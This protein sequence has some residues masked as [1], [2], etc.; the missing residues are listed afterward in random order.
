MFKRLTLNFVL[1]LLFAFAQIGAVRHE[2]SH[3]S[4]YK[5][6]QQ[7]N[8]T[9]GEQCKQCISYAE[10]TGGL[11]GKSFVLPAINA[12][13]VASTHYNISSQP[14]LNASYSARAPPLNT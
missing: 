7:D 11:V 13:F 12:H 4:H 14:A 1:V 6:N 3:F 2:I 10:V 5:Q 8:N 9:H